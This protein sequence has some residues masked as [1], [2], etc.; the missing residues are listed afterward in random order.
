[1]DAFILKSEKIGG[2]GKIV[3]IDESKFGKRKYHRGHHIEGQWVF[4]GYERGTGRVFMV[5][6]EDRK[7]T[8]L[9]PLIE[10]WI[11]KGTTI[12]SD[13]WK[14]YDKL[15]KEGYQHLTVNHSILF[16]NP[17]TGAHTNAIESSW[18]HAKVAQATYGRRKSG[19]PGNLAKYMFFKHCAEKILDRTE[20]FL[21]LAGQLYNPLMD[22][23]EQLLENEEEWSE[24]ED[25]Q[26]IFAG[27]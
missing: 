8:T 19:I 14:A 4:G 27:I 22:E 21:R 16:K 3:E 7:A 1:M 20:E 10:R 12:I 13:C 18:R 25:G 26:D 24:E 11:E 5:V 17:E 15:D 6:V 9:V 23:V 2:L